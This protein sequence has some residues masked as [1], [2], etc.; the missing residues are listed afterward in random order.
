M[1]WIRR[2]LNGILRIENLVDA[3]HR[4][5]TFGDAVCGLRKVFQWL[6]DAIKNHHIENESRRVN[7]RMIGENERTA[8]PEHKHDEESAKKF[9]D[10]MGG[11]L[12]NRYFIGGL[13]E[14]VGTLI[15][16]LLHLSLGR[17]CLDNAHTAQCL[18]KLRHG[19]APFVLRVEALALQL[20]ADF[21]HHPPHQRENNDGEDGELPTGVEQHAEIA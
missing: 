19:L 21:S 16:T 20:S 1:H 2:F 12:A 14:S 17:K 10:W 3:L 9:T 11:S 15:E 7:W 4:S 5:H 18:F 6:D 13:A 8:I